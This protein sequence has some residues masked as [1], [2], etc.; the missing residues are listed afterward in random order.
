MNWSS[1]V[2]EKWNSQPQELRPHDATR[3]VFDA[4]K[5]TF[6]VTLRTF[7]PGDRF[8]PWGLDGSLKLK[9]LFIDRKVPPDLRREFPLLVKDEE[10]LWVPGIRRGQAAA[11]LPETRRILEVRLVKGLDKLRIAGFP[12]GTE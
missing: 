9:K 3:A 12:I 2:R 11:V 10:I 8:R 5:A 7:R 4:D 1:Q 6:P